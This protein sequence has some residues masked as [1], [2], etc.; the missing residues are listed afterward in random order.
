[1]HTD[2]LRFLSAAKLGTYAAGN[3]AG[4]MPP[5]FPGWHQLAY[6][7]GNWRYQDLYA[8]G[9]YFAGQES[10]F[11]SDQPFWSMVYAGGLTSAQPDAALI[12]GFLQSALRAMPED[13]PLRGPQ[14][15]QVEYFTYHCQVSGDLLR[16][17]GEEWISF[18]GAPVYRLDFSGGKL[19]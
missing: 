5:L 4:V 7:Q 9:E 19:L 12:Y 10:V 16:F 15:F 17:S 8:G 13:L 14:V 6:C 3:G 2:F 18:K 11:Y 1:M